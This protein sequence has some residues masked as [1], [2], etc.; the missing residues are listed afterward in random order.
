MVL[1]EETRL[2]AVK[3]LEFMSFRISDMRFMRV[4]KM[5]EFEAVAHVILT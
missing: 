5:K 3:E 2:I 4:V 1:S